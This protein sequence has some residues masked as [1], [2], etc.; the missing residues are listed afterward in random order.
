MIHKNLRTGFFLFLFM[1][2]LIGCNQK[3]TEQSKGFSITGNIANIPDGTIYLM[4]A[5]DYRN[6]MINRIQEWEDVTAVTGC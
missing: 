1:L 6:L 5:G 2:M 3:K 4:K